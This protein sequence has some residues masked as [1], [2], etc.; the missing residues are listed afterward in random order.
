M[1]HRQKAFQ[2]KFAD[3]AKLLGT[4]AE[5]LVSLKVRDNVTSYEEYHELIHA[6]DH[7]MGINSQRIQGNFKG[8]GYLV[9][10]SNTKIIIVEHETG[11]EILYIAGSIASL[12][13][14]VPLVLRC[15]STVHDHYHGRPRPPGFRSI[16]IR[17]VDGEGNLTEDHTTALSVPWAE[18][19]SVMNSSILSAAEIIDAE[20]QVLKRT[21]EEL[22]KRLAV[23]EKGTELRATTKSKKASKAVG[24]R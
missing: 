10:N 7:E 1:D 22:E 18:P 6:L 23:V 17:R 4:A 16:E 20:M 13:G 19:L 24:K 9:E 2:E 8:N 15:W 14:L 12:I 5:Q 3:G 21:V 11:L